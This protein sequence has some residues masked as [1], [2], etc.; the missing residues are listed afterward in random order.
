MYSKWHHLIP[1]NTP[2]KA[3]IIINAMQRYLQFD[4]YAGVIPAGAIDKLFTEARLSL[5]VQKAAIFYQ[6]HHLELDP[7]SQNQ[8]EEMIRAYLCGI[9]KLPIPSHDHWRHAYSELHK[10]IRIVYERLSTMG[11]VELLLQ[12][13]PDAG[14]IATT[15]DRFFQKRDEDAYKPDQLI[16]ATL[17]ALEYYMDNKEMLQQHPRLKQI[18]LI[19][20]HL[21]GDKETAW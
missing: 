5:L 11:R 14:M 4:T 10:Q 8:R 19:H 15:I 20:H 3:G 13:H 17:R 2:E 7:L 12:D 9:I 6:K 18:E 16:F 1:D 21:E